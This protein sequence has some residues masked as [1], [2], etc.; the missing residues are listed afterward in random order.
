MFLHEMDHLEGKSMMHWSLSEGNI[1][2]LRDHQESNVHFMSTVQFY[3]TK[4]DDLKK[5][6][7]EMFDDIRKYEKI[8]DDGHEWK[9]FPNQERMHDKLVEDEKYLAPTFEET[10]LIDSI[11]AIRKDKKDAAR[12]MNPRK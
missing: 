9:Q 1:D 11:R 10:M 4:I 8:V 7:I 12:R 2:V 3:K 5:N 6:F